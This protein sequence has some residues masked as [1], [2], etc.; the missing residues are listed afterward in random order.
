MNGD[1]EGRMFECLVVVLVGETGGKTV[2]D[3]MLVG[4]MDALWQVRGKIEAEGGETGGRFGVCCW[5]L[6]EGDGMVDELE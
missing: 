1:G 2:L 4:E 3:S 5:G 6:P